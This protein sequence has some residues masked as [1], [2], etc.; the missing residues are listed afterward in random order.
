MKKRMNLMI[1]RAL[2]EEAKKLSGSE[3]Y[4][5]TIAKSL[6]AVVRRD[7]FR[8][9]FDELIAHAEKGSVFDAGYLEEY[10]ASSHHAPARR[11]RRSADE[12][13]APR[14]KRRA[15]R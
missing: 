6:E 4:S 13:R 1:N 8:R 15:A 10:E 2:L 11:Q 14:G 7:R 12:K 3:S 9:A 5:E